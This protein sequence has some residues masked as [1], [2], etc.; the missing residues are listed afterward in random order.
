MSSDAE[1]RQL[2]ILTALAEQ[3][4][5]GHY[6]KGA[7]GAIPGDSGSGLFRELPVHENLDIADLGVHAT[8][9][10]WG[11]CRGRYKKVGGKRF[12]KGEPDRDVLLPEYLKEL[13]D[14]ILPSFF[15]KSFNG[16]GLYPRRDSGYLYLGEDC[17][18]KR[19]F[20]CEG[21]IAWVL[22]KA[23]NKDKGT[24]RKGVGWYQSGGDGRLTVYKAVGN[25]YVNSA[26][27]ETITQSEIRDGDILINKPKPGGG[28][29]IAFA[30]QKGNGV[31]EAS[32]KD[33]GVLFSSYHPEWTE[34]A[35]IKSL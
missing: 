8:K 32:G 31:L 14:G 35:R 7:D 28:E 33:R 30:L 3:Q 26:T 27:G 5:G 17:R 24:W 4:K 12:A 2:I 16:T 9:N 11:T 29:H 25:K 23:L 19:H 21:Y 15:W 34:L 10:S 1:K 18:G 20:D 13:E 6:L 22:V